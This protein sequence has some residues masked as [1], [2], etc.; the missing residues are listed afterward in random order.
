MDTKVTAA[1]KEWV[2]ITGYPSEGP[3]FCTVKLYLLEVR[4]ISSI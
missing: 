4:G 2:K 3:K 1:G